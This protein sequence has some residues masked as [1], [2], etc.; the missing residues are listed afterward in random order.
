MTESRYVHALALGLDPVWRRLG[1]NE[2]CQSAE[3]F[4]AAVT[5]E[6]EVTTFT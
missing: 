1:R 3:D 4:C 2:R 6:S 5:R